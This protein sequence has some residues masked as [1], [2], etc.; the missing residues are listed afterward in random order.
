MKKLFVFHYKSRESLFPIGWELREPNL[1]ALTQ[2]TRA[3]GAEDGW[4]VKWNSVRCVF[5]ALFQFKDPSVGISRHFFFLQ[6][7]HSQTYARVLLQ[8]TEL[9]QTL[10]DIIS[11]SISAE[12]HTQML[13]QLGS[14]CL[15][16]WS[17]CRDLQGEIIILTTYFKDIIENCLDCEVIAGKN[18]SKR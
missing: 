11:P 13:L 14:T 1:Q 7:M 8:H 15:R 2:P 17:I 12:Y 9:S 10:Q 18:W 4:C 5:P 3:N 6:R 16:N